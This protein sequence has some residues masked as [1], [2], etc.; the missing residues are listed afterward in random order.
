MCLIL[1]VYIIMSIPSEGRC[2]FFFFLKNTPPTEI[3]PL[4]LHA[5]L[6]TSPGRFRP[7]RQPPRA[8]LQRGP[9]LPLPPPGRVRPVLASNPRRRH[10][11]RRPALRVRPPPAGRAGDRKSTR[12]NS[13]HSP[14]SYAVFCL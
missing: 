7:D 9:F 8:P 10:R 6:P 12:L 13:S 11:P 5:A 14:I 3:S 2:F 4:P 1:V